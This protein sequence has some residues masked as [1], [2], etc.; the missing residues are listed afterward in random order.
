MNETT[1]SRD[2]REL[3]RW[4]ALCCGLAAVFVACTADDRTRIVVYSPHGPELLGS[5]EEAFEAAYPEVDVVWQD[6]GAQDAYDRIRTERQNPQASVWWG[7][8]RT[9]FA[10]A[11]EEGLLAVYTPSWGDAVPDEARDSEGRWFGTFLTPSVI[12][13]N[14]ERVDSIDAPTDWDDL[15][16]AQWKDRI[17][18]RSPLASGTMRT[19]FG[20]MMLRQPT[21]DDGYRWLARLDQNTAS[22]PADPTQLYLQL[23]RGGGD[24]TLWNLPDILLQQQE[25]G[26]PFGYHIPSSGTPIVVDAI[27]ILEGAPEPEWAQRFYEFV[28][29]E[30]AVAAQAARFYRIPTRTDISP[31]RL[32]EWMQL[33]DLRAMP[34]DWALLA[35]EGPGWMQRWDEEVRGRG[36]RFLESTGR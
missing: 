15:L 16:D 9:L 22:Y 28:T 6:M 18:I 34:L 30:E 27:A 31:E 26:Y 10:R 23:A 5:Y 24:V 13:Y 35:D 20:A 29:S 7:A 17:V 12:A 8:P 25:H 3:I 11:A 33:I 4:V 1:Y 2:G 19:L 36:S 32:P 14:T 21:L